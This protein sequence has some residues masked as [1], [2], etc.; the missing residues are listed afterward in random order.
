[1]KYLYEGLQILMKYFPDETSMYTK[2]NVLYVGGN[3]GEMTLEDA[4]DLEAIPNWEYDADY[5]ECWT[6]RTDTGE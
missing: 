3:I 4:D 1:M 2:H 5:T 6:Y